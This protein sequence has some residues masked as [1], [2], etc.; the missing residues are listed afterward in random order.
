MKLDE[1]L[2]HYSDNEIKIEDDDIL[3]LIKYLC[4]H[5]VSFYIIICREENKAYAIC[6]TPEQA[7]EKCIMLESKNK[8]KH[9]IYNLIHNNQ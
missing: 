7:T 4:G 3:S 8:G 1:S 6:T 5:G 9:F 2:I